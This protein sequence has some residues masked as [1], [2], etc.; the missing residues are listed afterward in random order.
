MNE[1]N[2]ASAMFAPIWR[3]KWLILAV[4][5]IVGVATYFY[6]HHKH[7]TFGASTQIY[8]GAGAEELQ[9]VSGSNVRK[10]T[11]LE[12][13]S[14]TVLINSPIIRRAVRQEL[15]KRR[16][17]KAVK[18][19]LTGK[20]KAKT[21]EKSQ[22]ITITAEAH[23]ARGAALLTDTV[24]EAY[25]NRENGNYRRA[26]ESA[27]NLA[28]RQRHRLEVGE[29]L[30]AAEAA[31]LAKKDKGATSTKGKGTSTSVALQIAQLSSKVNQLESNL[32]IVNVRQVGPAH[33]EE[34][35]ASPK[36]NAIFGFVVGLLL[37]CFAAYALAR[38]DNRVRTISEIESALGA[39]ILTA[40]PA[41]RRPVVIS[42]G[43][44]RPSRLLVD[45]VQRLSTAL[46][47]ATIPGAEGA[48]APR[49]V[50]FLSPSSGDGKSTVVAD[51]ALIQRDAGA[52][53]AIVEA[54][55]RRPTLGRVLGIPARYGLAEVLA[56]RLGVDEALQPVAGRPQAANAPEGPGVPPVATIVQASGSASL[57][58]GGAANN[59]SVLLAS[60]AMGE[61]LGALAQ[62]HDYVLVDA[63]PPL[64]VSDAIP[65]LGLVDAVVIVARA[66]QT[67][68]VA[69]QR[70]RELLART[71]G[72]PVLGA[73]ANG[74]SRRDLER[75]GF[76]TYGEKGW[77]QRLL[78]G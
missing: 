44:P 53:V 27:L 9:S 22:F 2:D 78:R 47:F 51:L 19:A 28:K 48:R 58:V 13:K 14:Q 32:S 33:A 39:Q 75:Y 74:V 64:E 17:D 43:Q 16:R 24:A 73:V 30:A 36:R 71:A 40:L 31:A 67:R 1:T 62:D 46:R 3:R 57:L 25:V 41:V 10:Q 56:G 70:L 69:A 45:P 15:K 21:A 8:L 77:R 65:L 52:T 66:G 4:G 18:G 26:V 29:E 11:V 63:P 34:L 6:Y 23:N 72:A 20:Y 60:R 35:S 55:M 5:L 38:L 59:P 49:T 7:P 68:V 37:A 50:L 61:T 76:S 54:D 12:A 42:E